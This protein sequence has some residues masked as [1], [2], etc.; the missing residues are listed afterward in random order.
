M[1]KGN[2]SSGVTDPDAERHMLDVFDWFKTNP[3]RHYHLRITDDM[4]T[5]YRRLPAEML[6]AAG[7]TQDHR[8]ITEDVIYPITAGPLGTKLIADLKSA[9]DN[10][11]E[12][13]AVWR[14]AFEH[15]DNPPPLH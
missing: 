13:A 9:R 10:D 7:V 14:W 11:A 1:S 2:S 8:Q 4:I 12:L 3:Q 6:G 5:I 15:S